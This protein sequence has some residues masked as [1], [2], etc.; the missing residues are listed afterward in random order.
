MI[1]AYLQKPVAVSPL[2]KGQLL[3]V[4]FASQFRLFRAC[5]M[6]R[7]IVGQVAALAPCAQIMGLVVT[8]VMVQVGNREHDY[9]ACD[10]MSVSVPGTTAGILRAALTGIARPEQYS[11][12]NLRG[13]I[14]RIITIINRHL[15]FLFFMRAFFN[16]RPCSASSA[17]LVGVRDR[18]TV[19]ARH[20][21]QDILYAPYSGISGLQ[22]NLIRRDRQCGIFGPNVARLSGHRSPLVPWP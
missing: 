18:D 3:G 15:F 21:E 20:R 17:V 16:S 7:G 1:T 6:Q 13:P 19:V 11:W 5:R 12:P 4:E 2:P 14:R 8:G 22:S 10:R 9:T